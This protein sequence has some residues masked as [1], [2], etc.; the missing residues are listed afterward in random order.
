MSVDLAPMKLETWKVYIKVTWGNP[1]TG[2]DRPWGFQEVKAHT[3]HDNQHMKVVR[4][5]ALPTGHLIPQEI[6]LVLI[7]VRGWAHPRATVQPEGLCQ[8][9]ITVTPSGI[10]LRDLQARSTVPQ[11]TAPPRGTLY[12]RCKQKQP[13][14]HRLVLAKPPSKSMVP[15]HHLKCL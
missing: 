10:E 6:F 1:C 14:Q 4:L 9:K 11:P 3:L 8:W 2:L 12:I 5:L 7:F 15:L 13:K